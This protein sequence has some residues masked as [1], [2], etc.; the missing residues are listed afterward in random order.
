MASQGDALAAAVAEP[1]PLTLAA[2]P[3]ALLLEVLSRL[4]VDCRLRCAAV[5]RAW[6]AALNER[7]LWLRLDLSSATGGLSRR[8]TPRMATDGLL[9]AAAAR[10]AGHLETLDVSGFCKIS[11]AALLRVVRGNSAS[12]RE[13]DLSGV[14][15]R[16][17]RSPAEV[18]VLLRAAPRLRACHAAVFTTARVEVARAMLRADPPFAALRLRGLRVEQ[19]HGGLFEADAVLALAADLSACTSIRE[20]GLFLA[21]LDGPAVLDALVD[22]AITC[23]LHALRLDYCYLSAASAPALA[24]LLRGGALAQLAIA[25]QGDPL[26]NA[27][28]AAV[29]ANVLRACSTL[30]ALTLR[31]VSLWRHPVVVTALLGALTGHAS[32]R[33][34]DLSYNQL[35]TADRTVAGAALGA[36]VSANAPALTELDV[37]DCDLANGGLRPL[38]DALPSNTHLAKMDCS[39]NDATDAF[40]CGTLLPAVRANGSLRQLRCKPQRGDTTRPARHALAEA[41]ALVAQR[42]AGR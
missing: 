6:R 11:S 16:P 15:R 1:A 38:L 27:P 10:A 17:F 39:C 29:L 8:R 24:R 30:T 41:E 22:A 7:S 31:S 12:L 42:A 18:E 2:L 19:G 26:L 33:T 14:E 34:L 36:L 32:L 28:A 5:C 25:G 37:S 23:R 4:P 40:V 3:H 9:R 35:N 13:V 20:F 21:A